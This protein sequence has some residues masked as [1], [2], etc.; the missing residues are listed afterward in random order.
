MEEINF[1]VNAE[2]SDTSN[3]HDDSTSKS[4]ALQFFRSDLDFQ[5]EFRDNLLIRFW[6][7]LRCGI[8]PSS[9]YSQE[10]NEPVCDFL[11]VGIVLHFTR[12]STSR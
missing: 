7:L 10:E 6:A 4:L 3:F 1:H 8:F 12:I 2:V 5:L 11:P 9:R